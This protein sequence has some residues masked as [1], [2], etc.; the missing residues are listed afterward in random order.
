MKKRLLPSLLAL[1]MAL[2]MLPATALAAEGPDYQTAL[3][4][5]LEAGVRPSENNLFFG[6]GQWKAMEE[7][8]EK[9]TLSMRYAAIRKLDMSGMG[10]TQSSSSD[11]LDLLEPFLGLEELD[12]S[13][14]EDTASGSR[15]ALNNLDG[16]AGLTNL[17]RLDVSNNQLEAKRD[18]TGGIAGLAGCVRLEALDLSGNKRLGSTGSVKD[19][20]A[21]L[22]WLSSL[23][24]LD[25]SD[26]AFSDSDVEFVQASAGLRTLDISNTQVKNLDLSGLTGLTSLTARNLTLDSLKLPGGI[27]KVDLTGTKLRVKTANEDDAIAAVKA[28]GDSGLKLVNGNSTSQEVY[29]VTVAD[30]ANGTVEISKKT[31]TKGTKVTIT[32]TPDE[33]YVQ[34]SVIISYEGEDG[35][36]VSEY[37]ADGWFTMPDVN[38][39]VTVRFMPLNIRI[40]YNDMEHGTV[41]LDKAAPARRERVNFKTDLSRGFQVREITASIGSKT[42]P[43]YRSSNGTYC[44]D[45]PRIKE[46]ETLTFDVTIVEVVTARYTRSGSSG[47][48]LTLSGLVAGQRYVCQM[49][50]AGSKDASGSCTIVTFMAQDATEPLEVRG[51]T[52]GYV[53]SL[54]KYD[55]WASSVEDLTNVFYEVTAR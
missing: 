35:K 28:Y 46:G 54:W 18:Q 30:T 27:A 21:P 29:V 4:A 49:S 50:E 24:E 45:M 31:A 47:G 7:G 52:S 20:L 16:L 44:F 48:R 22:A 53:V 25:L 12:L 15:N 10:L 23:R 51:S 39:T 36:L 55:A 13:T 41:S 14:K 37:A 26:T 19:A 40:R 34:D 1:V 33:G 5:Q 9:W 3:I 38:V 6:I 2:V 8:L 11:D 42:V 32:V 17:R 43:V